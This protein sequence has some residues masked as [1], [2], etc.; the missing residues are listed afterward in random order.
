MSKYDEEKCAD[1]YKDMLNMK[2]PISKKH[3]PMA[4]EARVAQFAPFAAMVGHD[5][6]IAETARL[7]EQEHQITEEMGAIINH[8][9]NLIQANL[10]KQKV[11]VDIKYFIPDERKSGGKYLNI[12]GEVKKIDTYK[13]QVIMKD[14]TVVHIDHI[15]EING[16]LFGDS[17]I[18]Y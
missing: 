8:R 5:A 9:L 2:R 7:T 1:K 16:K 13:N 12:V 14:G 4:R 15:Y 10:A 6:A 17:T 3:P 11:K 18:Y